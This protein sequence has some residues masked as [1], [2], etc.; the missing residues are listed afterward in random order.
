MKGLELTRL[1]HYQRKVYNDI[2]KLLDENGKNT[3]ITIDTPSGTGKTTLLCSLALD[4]E[5]VKFLTFRKDQASQI[6]K[7]G[8]NAYTY[9]SF[10]MHHFNLSYESALEMLRLCSQT[11]IDELYTLLVYS[12]KFVQESTKIIILDMYTVPSPKL[13]LLLYIVSIKCNLHLIFA[14]NS[15]QL[16]AIRK[17]AFHDGSNFHVIQEFTDVMVNKLDKNMRAREKSFDQ[18]ITLFYKILRKYKP[19]GDVPFRF[20]LRYALYTICREKYFASDRFDNIYIAQTH[21][22]LTSRL[23]RFI[24]YLNLNGLAYLQAPF[25]YQGRNGLQPVTLK[26]KN[27]R[28][29]FLPYLLLVEGYKYI[30]INEEGVHHVVILDKILHDPSTNA[31]SLLIRLADDNHSMPIEIVACKL[32]YYQILPA[33]R[34]WLLKDATSIGSLFQ[35][36]LRPYTV[37]TYHATLGR[38][39]EQEDVELNID[40]MLA[41]YPYIGLCSVRY[42]DNIHKIHDERN[43]PNYVITEYMEEERDDD[44]YYYRCPLMVSNTNLILESA[45]AKGRNAYID[46][47]EWI[48]VNKI[49]DF[50]CKVPT[51]YMRIERNAYEEARID[52]KDTPLMRIAK[53]V[54]ERPDLI[55]NTIKTAPVNGFIKTSSSKNSNKKKKQK[56]ENLP[57]EPEAYVQ[58]QNAY[59]KWVN[60]MKREE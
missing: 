46:G 5:H 35:F 19:A 8:I 23:L 1:N 53:F 7:A 34:E 24:D 49:S 11:N 20:N 10:V 30:Y 3:I 28:N 60:T 42:Y 15:T 48:T 50:E 29:K 43:L 13:L 33:Y 38:T 47:I 17:S 37:L 32:N 41:N 26:R 18:K 58:L 2:Q 52:E 16:G 45:F 39:I 25:Y 21:R 57:P 27:D 31:H 56:F 40:C 36:P 12:K 55:V 9:L 4:N 59:E 6:R 54:K 14:G 51:F 22:Q 44:N